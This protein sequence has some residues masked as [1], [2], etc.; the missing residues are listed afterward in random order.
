[1]MGNTCGWW[2]NCSAVPLPAS[3]DPWGV[4]VILFVRVVWVL[5]WV[6]LPLTVP[7]VRAVYALV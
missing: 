2:R 3:P 4:V 1:M 5:E 6:I 7:L